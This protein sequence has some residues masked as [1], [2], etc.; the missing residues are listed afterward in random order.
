MDTE[1]QVLR[2]ALKL[3]LLLSCGSFGHI[4]RKTGV[5]IWEMDGEKD[6]HIPP[7]IIKGLSEITSFSIDEK[8]ASKFILN[9]LNIN[10]NGFLPIKIEGTLKA[11]LLFEDK[12]D[13]EIDNL[14][15]ACLSLVAK[16][17]SLLLSNIKMREEMKGMRAH[18][19][20]I[21]VKS[22]AAEKLAS[23]GTIAAGL[24]HEIKNPLV[25]IKT[26][27]QLLPEKF[28]DP[29]FRNHFTNIAINEVDR[30]SSIVSGLLDF[31]K[32][33]E[34]RFE[35]LD[36]R[37][38]IEAILVMLSSQF[39]KNGITIQNIFAEHIPLIYGDQFQLKQV[40]LNIFLN[41]MEAMP[42]GGEIIAEIASGKDIVHGESV[43]VK[44]SDTGSGIKEED[45]AHLFEPFF[46]T[47]GTGTGL[48]LSICKTILE[49]Q[50]GEIS[51]ESTYNKGTTVTLI[52]PVKGVEGS[53]EN[54]IAHN[55]IR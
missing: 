6:I 42:C 53:S 40:L 19:E 30:I 50:H 28:D 34:L 11:V 14:Y 37:R 4:I 39:V 24:A 17:V 51:I 38:L 36:M 15:G 49:K 44:I 21:I 43:F 26:L 2:H 35:S 3:S 12:R 31:A 32:I 18:Y 25:S 41:S 1:T 29:E 13:G 48:G 55:I 23:L 10:I 45:K 8:E 7:A 16:Y 5:N 47:K 54:L 46:T 33:S 27:A 9:T 20:D 52:L 22:E